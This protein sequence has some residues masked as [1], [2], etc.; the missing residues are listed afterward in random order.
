MKKSSLD[1]NVVATRRGFLGGLFAAGAGAFLGGCA[2]ARKS[3][4]A[5]IALN[6]STLRPYGLALRQ[7]FVIA[8]A[9]GFGGFE[10][11]MK[12]VRAAKASGELRDAIAFARDNGLSIV[13]GI[14]FGQWTNP[15][16]AIR[17]AGLEETK[18]DMA[19]LAEMGC[20]FVAASMFGVHKPGSPIL[21]N[22]EIAERF[23]AVCAL[24]DAS[25]VKPLLEY[26][27]HSVNLRTLEDALDVLAKVGRSDTAVLADVYHT[28]RG[29]GDFAAF[30]RLKAPQLPVLHVNDYRLDKPRET[31]VDADRV[32]PGDGA[33][34]WKRIFD[35]LD[36]VG[37]EPWLSAELFRDEYCKVR[38][39][40][41]AKTCAKK[42]LGLL[43]KYS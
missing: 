26:W 12:D 24:G 8:V 36:D 33:A 4:R 7:Q 41:C 28:Y 31:L 21:S 14:A 9:G 27:G 17:A 25:G 39:S 42:C 5:R 1:L 23:A 19:L 20:P 38:P 2:T 43:E 11:W 30:A 37:A 6:A 40:A 32:W 35:A 10:P 29:G 3:P 16:A 22:D 34:P 13:N 15:D 18:R